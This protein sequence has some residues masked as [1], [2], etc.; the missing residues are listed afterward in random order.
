MSEEYKTGIDEC[1]NNVKTDNKFSVSLLTS[2]E[3]LN[4]WMKKLD[5]L[6]E[7]EDLTQHKTQYSILYTIFNEL[8][9][10]HSIPEFMQKAIIKKKCKN[11]K[12]AV[13]FYS[14]AI[15]S[16]NRWYRHFQKSFDRHSENYISLVTILIH[17]K[18]AKLLL[19]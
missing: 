12:Q 13:S 15:L 4:S 5:A 7:K 10:R 18:Y 2:D 19:Q 3:Y 9:E 14:R 11:F 1:S 8:I 6:K 17:T 16:L